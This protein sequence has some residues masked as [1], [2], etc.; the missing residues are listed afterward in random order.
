MPPRRWGAGEVIV[1]FGEAAVSTEPGE[2][3][4]AHIVGELLKVPFISVDTTSLVPSGIV[5][6]QIE[7]VLADLV[8]EA[9]DILKRAGRPRRDDDDIAL[10]RRGIVFFDEFDK[11]S[12]ANANAYTQGG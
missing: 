7:D 3:A 9:D 1:V 11:I 4:L 2:H 12:T 6:Y 8:R 10:A 5:G